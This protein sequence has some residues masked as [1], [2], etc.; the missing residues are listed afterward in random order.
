MSRSDEHGGG[1]AVAGH[2]KSHNG[3]P[4]VAYLGPAG[5]YTEQAAI[6]LAGPGAEL[7]SCL[8]VP[9]AIRA[10]MDGTAAAAVVPAENALEGAVSATM[11]FLAHEPR[12]PQVTGEAV[13]AVHHLLAAPAGAVLSRITVVYS[14]PQALAQCR[15][16]L[17]ALLPHATQVAAASTAEA[18]RLVAAGH[19]GVGVSGNPATAACI[20]SRRAVDLHGLAVISDDVQDEPANATRFWLLARDQAPP[21]GR[22]K[23]SI[24]F[25]VPH[26]AGTL[27]EALGVFAGINLTRIES[28]PSRRS[29][30]EYLFFVDFEG[31]AGDPAPS[32]AL[33]Q[34]QGIA[35]W[36]RVLGSYRSAGGLGSIQR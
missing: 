22:D 32:R 35:D 21:T 33:A 6:D 24:V 16:R 30:G 10:V 19:A 27:H 2:H 13:V 12:A 8:S 29:L 15:G 3:G 20:A 23:T 18:A 25:S 11:D 4:V 1:A 17:E 34:L 5:T 14:H 26:R 7:L 36:V 31:H 28:R 9:A